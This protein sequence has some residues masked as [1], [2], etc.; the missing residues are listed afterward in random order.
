MLLQVKSVQTRFTEISINPNVRYFG[1]INVGQDV[2]VDALR[3]LYSVLVFAT[4]SAG[5]RKMDVP[6]SE[7]KGIHSAR[8]FVGW[9]NCLPDNKDDAYDLSGQSAVIIGTPCTH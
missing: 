4:G 8:D 9:Y 2:S 6:G 5:S 3:S 1:N 7:L